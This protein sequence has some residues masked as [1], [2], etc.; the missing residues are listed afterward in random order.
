MA[1]MCLLTIQLFAQNVAINNDGTPA[2]PSAMLDVKSTVKGMLVPRMATVERQ[3]ISLPALGLLVY[4]NS[5]ESFWYYKTSGWTELVTTGNPATNYWNTNGTNI[6]NNNPGFVGIGTSAPGA[7]LSLQT[8]YNTTSLRHVGVPSTGTDSIIVSLAVGG[9]SAAFGTMSNHAFRINTNGT[10]KISIYPLGE[11]VVGS[12][13]TG[14]F[15]KFTVETLN[16]SYGISHLGENGN[17][18]ATRMGGTSAGIGT[19]SNTNMRIFCNSLSAVIIAAATGNVGIGTDNPDIYKLAVN[20]T[21]RAKEVRINTG[22]ADY[23]FNKNYKLLPLSTLGKYIKNNNH[24]PGI[25]G[26]S[27]LKAEGVDI[28]TMQT[29]MMA[30]IEELTL[31]LINADKSIHD[32]KT[33]LAVLDKSNK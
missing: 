29:K 1:V 6:Y 17:I 31:Y 32:L 21:I 19:F 23:V 12:N 30:K 22:W 5:T 24:L 14:A 25:P 13:Q 26:A 18:L 15:G 33:R 7:L 16:N 20:G 10:G 8:P 27:K 11:V 9:V 4:D 2:Q 3:G 28:S